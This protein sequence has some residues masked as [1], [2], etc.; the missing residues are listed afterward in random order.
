MVVAPPPFTDSD[1]DYLSGDGTP[2][3]ETFVHLY[4][5]LVTLE[6]LRQYL[7]GHYIPENACC[8]PENLQKPSRQKLWLASRLNRRPSKNARELSK[9]ANG[10]R[11]RSGSGCFESATQGDGSG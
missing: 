8:C 5:L 3:A 6:V 10:L 11:G 9:N 1:I 4:A 2:V 7:D